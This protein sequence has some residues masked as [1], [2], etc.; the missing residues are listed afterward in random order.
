MATAVSTR[1]ARVLAAISAA[2]ISLAYALGSNVALVTSS[3]I[4]EELPEV[5]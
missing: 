4:K 3:G 5:L 1:E 2:A